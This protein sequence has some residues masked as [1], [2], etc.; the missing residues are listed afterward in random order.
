ME[1]AENKNLASRSS[2]F[3]LAKRQKQKASITIAKTKALPAAITS[4][5]IA[6]ISFSFR[7]SKYQR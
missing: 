1:C 2:P 3:A 4:L 7:E 6:P 5:S